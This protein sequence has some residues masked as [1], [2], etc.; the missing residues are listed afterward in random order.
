MTATPTIDGTKGV[1]DP[2]LTPPSSRCNSNDT[3]NPHA[4]KVLRGWC[5]SL[6]HLRLLGGVIESITVVSEKENPT[7]THPKT[8]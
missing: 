7:T 8:P 6:H 5:F 3:S 2:T 4:N 1:S